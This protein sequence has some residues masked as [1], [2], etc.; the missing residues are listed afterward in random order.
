MLILHQQQTG[1]DQKPLNAIN[2]LRE[3]V[4]TVSNE[5]LLLCAWEVN[6]SLVYFS[7]AP[8][9]RAKQRLCCSALPPASLVLACSERWPST[10]QVL[11]ASMWSTLPLAET[12]RRHAHA[13]KPLLPFGVN[14]SGS[15]V[16]AVLQWMCIIADV[17]SVAGS[18]PGPC[19]SDP[20]PGPDAASRQRGKH[21]GAEMRE[22]LCFSPL[23]WGST[24]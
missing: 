24:S 6:I 19:P 14:T 5:T 23:H 7:P 17:T 10:R 3:K 22:P 12:I 9:I 4:K 21:A 8:A 2:Q 11:S 1:V 13:A 18:S 15:F 20:E 16:K